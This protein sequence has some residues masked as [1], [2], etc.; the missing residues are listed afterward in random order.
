MSQCHHTIILLHF[1][2]I[3]RERFNA[4]IK[5]DG[6][7]LWEKMSHASLRSSSTHGICRFE[8]EGTEKLINEIS[9]QLRIGESLLCNEFV[10]HEWK[11]K[12]GISSDLHSL[13]KSLNFDSIEMQLQIVWEIWKLFV[14]SFAF[15]WKIN[16]LKFIRIDVMLNVGLK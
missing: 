8:S 11:W 5:G 6:I 13:S 16:I 12:E 2:C 7:R 3:D 14:I 15:L 1:C 10:W 4:L 9:H